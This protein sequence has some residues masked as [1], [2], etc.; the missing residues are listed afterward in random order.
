VAIAVVVGESD[1]DV[2]EGDDP[3]DMFVTVLLSLVL[4]TGDDDVPVDAVTDGVVIVVPTFVCVVLVDEDASLFVVV[5]AVGCCCDGVV[6]ELC[7][8]VFFVLNQ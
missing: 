7:R 8:L 2:D 4:G 1:D 3:F 6:V 5:V